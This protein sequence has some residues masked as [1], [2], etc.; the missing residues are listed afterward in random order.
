[1]RKLDCRPEGP[2]LALYCYDLVPSTNDIVWD[3]LAA[4]AVP[5]FAAIARCQSAG[6]G[7]WGR[8][9]QSEPGGLYCTLL[10]SAPPVLGREA[11]A[12]LHLTLTAAWGITSMLRA[13]G[14]PVA[15]KW[16]N[17]LILSGRKLGGILCQQRVRGSQP[18][19]EIA[20]GVGINWNNVV[21]PVAIALRSFLQEKN[22]PSEAFSHERLLQF[23][24][25]GIF[26]GCSYYK[27]EGAGRL[28][29]SYQKL[30][31][32]KGQTTTISGR[33]GIVT[34]VAP[35]GRLR[36]RFLDSEGGEILQA[37]GTLDLGYPSCGDASS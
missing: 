12:G 21:P 14:L 13:L 32:S 19:P 10:I 3:L 15:I 7:Q 23:V 2:V 37:P 9:W 20:I 6:R 18:R 5:P 31:T 17:D 16:P 1:M 30:L 27:R 11:V 24:L 8:V 35:D 26:E 33:E 36:L 28:L 29:A 22:Y 4:G 34:G 25:R